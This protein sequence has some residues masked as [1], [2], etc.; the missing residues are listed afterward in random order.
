VDDEERDSILE[1]PLDPDRELC[2]GH[3]LHVDE[4]RDEL[5]CAECGAR[6]RL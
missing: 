5:V 1:M 6:F 3:I 4:E 2:C